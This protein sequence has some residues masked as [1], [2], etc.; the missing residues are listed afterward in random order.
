MSNKPKTLAAYETT[1]TVNKETGEITQTSTAKV[2]KAEAEPNYI[3]MY[4][5]DLTYLNK[6]P[7]GIDSI[8]FEL[9]KYI[10]YEQEIIINKGI[11]SRIAEKLEKSESYINNSIVKLVKSEMLIRK[12]RGIYEI[13]SYIF[14]KGSWKDIIKHRKSLKLEIFYEYQNEKKMTTKTTTKEQEDIKELAEQII[15][16]S[17]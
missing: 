9:L 15:A 3:K 2:F 4:L 8:L 5:Q 1:E 14:G 11:K 12:D 10:N 13:N 16:K 7:K 17:A 6:L